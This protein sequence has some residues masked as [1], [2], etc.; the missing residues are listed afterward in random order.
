M[1]DRRQRLLERI[2]AQREALANQA[3]PLQHASQRLDRSLRAIQY[4]K[5]NPLLTMGGGALALVLLRTYTRSSWMQYGWQAW[6]LLRQL[7]R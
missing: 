1:N 5:R 6:R 4:L 3:V 2:A 7:R